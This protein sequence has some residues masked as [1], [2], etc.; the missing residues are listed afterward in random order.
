MHA[1]RARTDWPPACVSAMSSLRRFAWVAVLIVDAG[2]IFWGGMAA[3]APDHLLGPGSLPILRAGY[4]GYT[5]SSWLVLANASPRTA[6]FLTMMFR[7][8]GAYCAVFG[9]LTS[10]IAVTAFRRR[11][12]WSWWVLLIGNAIAF[13][14]AMTYDWKADAIGPFEASEY[15]GAALILIALAITAPFVPVSQRVRSVV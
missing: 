8:Y 15:L 6:E 11:E 1:L 10:A 14:Y 12:S 9:V 5:G 7:L 2:F 3:L 4:E 13:G